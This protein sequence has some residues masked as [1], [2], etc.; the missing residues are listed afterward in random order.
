MKI[1][2]IGA[3]G[4]IG[5]AVAE[6]LSE[7][8]EIVRAGHRDGDFQVDLGSKASIEALFSAVG[9][10]DAVICTAGAANFAPF[11]DLDDAAFD[12]ALTNKL[13]GQ[14]NLVRIGRD[15]V[16][17]SGSFTLTAGILSRDPM[18]GSVVISMANGALESFARAAA[19]ELDR[20]LRVNTVSPVFV[21][22]TMEM[23]GMDPTPGLSA[24]D[25]AKAYVAAVEGDYNG[26]TL[27]AP[28]YV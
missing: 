11:S 20:D 6:R 4:T 23:M 21:K 2:I 16:S 12:L 8:H 17:D 10:I 9:T 22:E 24:A 14:I 1:L 5:K 18:P 26:V 15:H 7:K 13:M 27:D 19:L 25:T 3:T 28:D